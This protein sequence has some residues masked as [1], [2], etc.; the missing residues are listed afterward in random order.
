MTSLPVGVVEPDSDDLPAAQAN[1]ANVGN[2]ARSL[3]QTAPSARLPPGPVYPLSAKDAELE[4]PIMARDLA[5]GPA[6]DRSPNPKGRSSTKVPEPARNCTLRTFSSRRNSFCSRWNPQSGTATR[7][8]ALSSNTRHSRA[9]PPVLVPQKNAVLIM[10]RAIAAW[11]IRCACVAPPI[12]ISRTTKRDFNAGETKAVKTASCGRVVVYREV[13]T[14][15]EIRQNPMPKKKNGRSFPGRG[16]APPGM[17][18]FTGVPGPDT[19]RIQT[20]CNERACF[21]VDRN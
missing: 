13:A 14:H 9:C 11:T 16:R 21:G 2:I 19:V 1:R 18:C 12:A 5:V 4:L 8:S 10:D 15:E 6:C 7:L 20:C 17:A 3:R